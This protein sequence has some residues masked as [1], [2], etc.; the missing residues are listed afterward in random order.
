LQH[1]RTFW[2][3]YWRGQVWRFGKPG[4]G[5][6]V[7]GPGK[8]NEKKPWPCGAKTRFLRGAKKKKCRRMTSD[9][10]RNAA[11]GEQKVKPSFGDQKG[12]RRTTR[13]R[14]DG[15]RGKKGDSS[16]WETFEK[17]EGDVKKTIREAIPSE[18]KKV[19]KNPNPHVKL[20]ALPQ[21]GERKRGEAQ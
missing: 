1:H 13:P 15:R 5:G 16:N 18:E 20:Y 8:K 4:G 10:E 2:V 6:G 19:E 12:Q 14:G 17:G 11:R 21:G 9:V 7:G 3:N